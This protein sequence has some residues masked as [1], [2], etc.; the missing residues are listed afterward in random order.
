MIIAMYSAT[1]VCQTLFWLVLNPVKHVLCVWHVCL[2]A[3]LHIIVH[4]FLSAH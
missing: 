1:Y 3:F 2:F 4:V